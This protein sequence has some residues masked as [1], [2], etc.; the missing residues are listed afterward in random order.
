M[1]GYRYQN[2]GNEFDMPQE[3]D[4][5]KQE[6]GDIYPA[7]KPLMEKEVEGEIKNGRQMKRQRQRAQQEIGPRLTFHHVFNG[8]GK[9]KNPSS[10]ESC[11]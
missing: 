7:R 10:F 11:N 5:S 3:D 2:G 8:I 6:D 1:P 9:Q 4:V